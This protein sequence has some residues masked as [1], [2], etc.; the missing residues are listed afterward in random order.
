MSWMK[1]KKLDDSLLKFKNSSRYVKKKSKFEQKLIEICKL[2]WDRLK[3]DFNITI[4]V[5]KSSEIC[6]DT[7]DN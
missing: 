6:T 5:I 3:M 2:T 7:A 4:L 1:M